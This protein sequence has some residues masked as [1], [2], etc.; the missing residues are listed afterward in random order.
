MKY[1]LARRVG[2]G[3]CDTRIPEC[4]TQN[5]QIVNSYKT[6]KQFREIYE[7]GGEASCCVKCISIGISQGRIIKK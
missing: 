1:H 7:R 2:N 4:N 5:N 6:A 3:K